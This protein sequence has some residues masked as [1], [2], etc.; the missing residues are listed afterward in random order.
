MSFKHTTFRLTSIRCPQKDD[1][2]NVSI[3]N[4]ISV[5]FHKFPIKLK[6][7]SQM[8]KK[9]VIISHLKKKLM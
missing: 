2:E 8:L 1:K 9:N 7:G 6:I 3:K 4:V 5:N